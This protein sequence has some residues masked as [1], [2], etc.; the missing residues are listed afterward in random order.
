[1]QIKHIYNII[2]QKSIY[3]GEGMADGKALKRIKKT[4]GERFMK[5]CR[6]H[7]SSISSILEDDEKLCCSGK[8][9][10]LKRLYG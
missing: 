10:Y 4:Y 1:M 9:F 3:G 7:F 2:L 8:T 5:M 6:A